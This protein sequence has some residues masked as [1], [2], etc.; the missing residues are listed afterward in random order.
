MTV[1]LSV[2][3]IE[4]EPLIAMMIED[5]I[6]MLGH[7]LA[8]SCDSVAEALTKVEEGGFDVAILDVNLRDG[9][10]WPVADALRQRDVPFVLASGG[11]VEP[12]PAAHADA[13]QL[14]KP[15][16][17]DGIKDVLANIPRR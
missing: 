8:G 17:L 15:F 1:P 12:P 2:L 4:D 13:L 9:A 11:H 14:A 16:T 7:R 5:F 6:E 10:C 3:V